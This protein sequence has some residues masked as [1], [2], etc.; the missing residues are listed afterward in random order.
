MSA[1]VTSPMRP[2]S[3]SPRVEPKFEHPS[4]RR[5]WNV[6]LSGVPN[7]LVL[8]LLGSVLLLGHQTDWKM[9]K[10]S[11]LMGTAS[12]PIDD[13]CGEHLVPE[14]TCIECDADLLPRGEL[15]GFCQEHG[16]AE[17]V[18][19]HPELAQVDG[20]P[21]F[22]Q[23]D[24]ATA[25]ALKPRNRNNSRDRLHTRRVQFASSEVIEKAGIDVD[26]VQE[27]PMSEAITTHGELLFDPT[28]VAH[29]SSRAPGNV[30]AVFKTIGDEV[31][32]GEILALVDASLV[33]Q[34]KAQLLQ[35]IV[36]LQLKQ[37]TW[38]RLRSASTRGAVPQ[39]SVLEAEAAFQEA[40]VSLLCARQSLANLGLV[41]PD[42][43]EVSD[44]QELAEELRFV[45]LSPS[46]LDALPAGT[47]T[48]NLVPI[49][50]SFEGVLVAAHVV[51][52]EVVDTTT[53]M[54]TVCDPSRMWLLLN[55]RQED[56]PYVREGMPVEFRSDHGTQ[57][58]NGRVS[59]IS[60]AVDERTRTLQVRASIANSDGALRDKTFGTGRIILRHEPHAVV[61][62]RDAVQST[63]DG[64]FVFVRDKGY[65]EEGSVKFFHVRQVRIGATDDEY[66]E[67]LAGAL[68]GEV[69]A[70]TGSNV[71]LAQLLRC[72]LGAGCG[73]H[74][75]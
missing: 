3:T 42:R 51:V 20:R 32:A 48:A 75:H 6:V 25:I 52:G 12:T 13:W 65:F 70:T 61:V 63:P 1:T 21:S 26:L 22:P 73:C 7:V 4:S 8:C 57:R 58:V 60:P 43:L 35:S 30:A 23:Y 34:A 16:V 31:Q 18:L 45:G 28:H 14:S 71:L 44:P 10:M 2:V 68:P 9:P 53:S 49:R 39:N 62:T 40:R 50:A 64:H 55:V 56:A 54:F 17:C 47:S 46:V 27:R 38:E 36:Q 74:E 59:W 24:T 29:F 67:L 41:L 66:V 19:H 69:V 15:F 37:T 5:W 72:D 33:G 11:E